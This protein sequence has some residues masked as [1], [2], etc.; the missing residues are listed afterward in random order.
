MICEVFV[1]VKVR[2]NDYYSS[3]DF[4]TWKGQSVNLFSFGSDNN[5]VIYHRIHAPSTRLM[6]RFYFVKSSQQCLKKKKWSQTKGKD[7]REI[8]WIAL[9]TTVLFAVLTRKTSLMGHF[10]LAQLH[11]A[12]I[13]KKH[14]L[15]AQIFQHLLKIKINLYLFRCS[16]IFSMHLNTKRL[17]QPPGRSGIIL[18]PTLQRKKKNENKNTDCREVR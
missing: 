10:Q 9:I 17:R 1:I 12:C 4:A 2:F 16:N 14:C 11:T 6:C 8:T 18:L 5:W 7:A 3:P 15:Q 13:Q